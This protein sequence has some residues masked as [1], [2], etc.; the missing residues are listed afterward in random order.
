M[1]IM[2]EKRERPPGLADLPETST[3]TVPDQVAQQLNEIAFDIRKSFGMFG[4]TNWTVARV[5][6]DVLTVG[7]WRW[8]TDAAMV[9]TATNVR[10]AMLNLLRDTVPCARFHAVFHGSGPGSADHR[11]ELDFYPP[12]GSELPSQLIVIE[13][14]VE[15]KRQHWRELVDRAAGSD[16]YFTR[17]RRERTP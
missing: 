11:I 8:P 3:A 13:E 12:E 5:D 17:T 16:A 7:F 2:S 10:N 6:P 4:G 15:P 1:P 9:H 14:N